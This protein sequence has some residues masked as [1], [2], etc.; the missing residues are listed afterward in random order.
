MNV[1]VAPGSHADMVC[2]SRVLDAR[3]EAAERGLMPP[4]RPV[5]ERAAQ[6]GLL[7]PGIDPSPDHNLVDRHGRII[8]DL[9]YTNFYVG[10]SESWNT[11]DIRSIDKALAAAMSDKNLNNVMIQF[12]R[13][14]RITCTFKPSTILPGPAPQTVS[15]GDVENMIRTLHD[16]GTL[17]GFD[18]ASTVFNLMLPRN[19]ILTTDD[20]PSQSAKKTAK[21]ESPPKKPPLKPDLHDDD[22]ASSLEGLGGYHGSVNI[23]G[24]GGTVRVYYAVGAFS[25]QRPNGTQNGIPVFDKPWKNVVGTF[26]HELN[27]ARTDPDVEEA[28]RNNDDSFIGW[29]SDQGEECGDFPITEAGQL[30][31]LTLVFQQVELTDGSGTVPIQFQYSNFAQGPQG[32]STT[33]DPVQS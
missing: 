3:A 14:S 6:R 12:F 22:G 30:G 2:R 27:E 19:T 23:S 1:V 21:A 20:D 8:P 24:A 4:P 26:Y 10:G 25:E 5:P 17:G 32:P 28:I 31:D 11:N 18:F 29:N 9:I 13:G 15:K 33:P 16:Q 7:P